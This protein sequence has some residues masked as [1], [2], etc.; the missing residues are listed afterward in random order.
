MQALSADDRSPGTGRAEGRGK[1]SRLRHRSSVNSEHPARLLD[2]EDSRHY[3]GFLSSTEELSLD[4]PDLLAS[5]LELGWSPLTFI[6]PLPMLASFQGQV[7]SCM[8]CLSNRSWLM[9]LCEKTPA[10]YAPP[11]CS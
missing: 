3:S 2:R 9:M 4:V 6:K 5:L 10:G 8:T 7:E 11:Q 1:A